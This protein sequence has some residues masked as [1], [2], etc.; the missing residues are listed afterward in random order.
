MASHQPPV[1]YSKALDL[2]GKGFVVLGAGGGGIGT[3]TSIALAQN[4]ARL[5]CVDSREDQAA[6][7]AS[8]TG[9]KAHVADITSRSEME[10][11]FA[12]TE[13]TFG[14]AFEGVVDIVGMAQMGPIASFDDAAIER[15]FGSVFRHALLAIQIAGPM[16]AERGRGSMTFVGSVSGLRAVNNQAIYASAKA[17]LHHLVVQAAFEFGPRNVRF[18][19]IAPG[20]VKTPRLAAAIPA[21][22][23][24]AIS[25]TIPLRRVAEPADIA[26]AALFLASDLGGY[27]TGN[28]LTLDGAATGFVET[29]V[30]KITPAA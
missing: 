5:I 14:D 3:Q 1:D 20:F 2:S 15:Q 19:A 10:T 18:N 24:K 28:I 25:A 22:Q 12:I 17:A 4:G 11:L 9:G 16:L 6:E 23:W 7:V 13:E 30:I 8:L 27:V 26:R 21:A 29:P